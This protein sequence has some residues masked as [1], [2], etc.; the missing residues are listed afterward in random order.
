MG[1]IQK[2]GARLLPVLAGAVGAAY[3]LPLLASSTVG[4]FSR[5]MAD[6]FCTAAVA[7][8]LG[9]VQAEAYWYLGWSGRYAYVLLV[10]I[11]SLIGPGVV[12]VLPAVLIVSWLAA[13]A[14]SLAQLRPWVRITAP[15]AMLLAT[16]LVSATISAIPNLPQSLYW[17]NSSLTYT[18]PLVLGSLLAGIAL[19]QTARPGH[20]VAWLVV[21]ALAFFAGGFSEIYTALQFGLFG[22]AVVTAFILAGR[23]ARW[24]A[25]GP[26]L[27][28]LLGTAG[29]LAAIALAPGTHSRQATLAAPP[30]L[31]WLIANSRLYSSWFVR[32]AFL[33]HTPLLLA[34]AALCAMLAVVAAAHP[35]APPR[36]RWRCLAAALLVWPAVTFGLLMACYSAPARVPPAT[37]PR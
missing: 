32:D 16:V 36:P 21:L 3:L 34:V 20:P 33:Q 19:R 15:A 18:A 9:L 12:P 37:C 17:R 35:A 2:P 11:A 30:S 4:L 26:W 6:D 10:D 7:R 31:S 1:S 13:L 29:A 28:G 14:W 24:R 27:A 5:Y 25:S 8:T 22:L 23:K